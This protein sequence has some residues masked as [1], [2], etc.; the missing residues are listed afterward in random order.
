MLTESLE[1]K[2]LYENIVIVLYNHCKYHNFAQLLIGHKY[3]HQ[4]SG[5]FSLDVSIHLINLIFWD[6]TLIELLHV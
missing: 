3:V 4:K 2:F 6:M 1:F 5:A